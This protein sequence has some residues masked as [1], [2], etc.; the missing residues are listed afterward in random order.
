[1]SDDENKKW[2][3]AT[4][5]LI[6]LLLG[7]GI[8]GLVYTIMNKKKI[9]DGLLTKMGFEATS[10]NNKDLG[11]QLKE[12][13]EKQVVTGVQKLLNNEQITGPLKETVKRTL[14]DTLKD[15]TLL[16]PLQ[17]T[18][19]AEIKPFVERLNSMEPMLKKLAVF[20]GS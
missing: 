18:I 19:S 14:V 2:S 20:A 1:M 4:F 9:Q 15:P 7:V 6:F 11:S 17:K 8:A 10:V 12:A 3:V 13:V 16:T 5:V